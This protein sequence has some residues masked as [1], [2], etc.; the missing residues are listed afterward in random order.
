M[1]TTLKPKTNMTLLVVWGI[2]AVVVTLIAP[3]TQWLFLGV[4]AA[5]GVCAGVF[6]LRALRESSASLITT[7]TA[8]EVRLVLSSSRFGRRYICAFWASMVVLFALAFYLLRGRAFVGLLAGY[9]AF[10]FIRELLTLRGTFELRRLSLEQ[11][12]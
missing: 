7:Q 6:Q 8:M 5:L 1:H 3:P 10:A 4:G 11:R 2:A 9:S 12:G